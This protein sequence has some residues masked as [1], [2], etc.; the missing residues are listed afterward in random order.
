LNTVEQIT[1]DNPEAGTYTFSVRG[2][3]VSGM[4]NFAFAWQLDT[5]HHF[6]FSYPTVSDP[7]IAGS[8]RYIRWEATDKGPAQL[9]YTMDGVNW[10]ALASLS[11]LSMGYWKWTLPDTIATL[12]LRMR[13]PGSGDVFSDPFTVSP[14]VTIQVGFNCVDSFLLYW[15]RLGVNSY[16]LYELK[17]NYLEPFAFVSKPEALLYKKQHPSVYFATAPVINGLTGYRSATINYPEAGVGC[18]LKSFF[19]QDQ[20][21]SSATFKA[22]LGSLFD[23]VSVTLE[24]FRDTGFQ[25]LITR[26]S[27]TS[28]DFSFTDVA[29]SQGENRYRLKIQLANGSVIYSTTESAFYTGTGQRVILYPNP[30]R[31]SAPLK[32]LSNQ[33]GR[34]SISI[35]DRN[36]RLCYQQELNSTVTFLNTALLPVGLYLVRVEDREGKLFTE[37][38]IIY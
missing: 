3:H 7:Q 32:I 2:S 18:Y 15:N 29:V 34:Y 37:K 1:L 8:S 24:K 27:P 16:R 20:S 19:L 14:E 36:G 31:Q 23:V 10:N 33:S 22:E 12:R 38:L 25:S 4:Q 28:L 17:D 35:I 30:V 11:D 5:V 9:D 21:G 26:V 6:H 13:M